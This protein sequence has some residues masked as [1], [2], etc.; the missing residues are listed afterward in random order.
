MPLS[1]TTK[2][3]PIFRLSI[4]GKCCASPTLGR[5]PTVSK[6]TY[7]LFFHKKTAKAVLPLEKAICYGLD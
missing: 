1:E 6:R 5:M 3:N 4:R 7:T 2:L